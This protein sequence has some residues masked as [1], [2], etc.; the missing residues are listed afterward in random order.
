MMITFLYN[1]NA[2]VFSNKPTWPSSETPG[3]II[4]VTVYLTNNPLL[5]KVQRLQL[6]NI[7]P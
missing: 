1:Y 4:V 5:T 6:C 2:R 3:S 7:N